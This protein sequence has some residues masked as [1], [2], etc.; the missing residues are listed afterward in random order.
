MVQILKLSLWSFLQF[1][2]FTLFKVQIFTAHRPET[3]YSLFILSER[4]VVIVN[5]FHDD[6][7]QHY[8]L[9]VKA[10]LNNEWRVLDSSV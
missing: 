10:S 8:C 9:V 1:P 6:T 4:A 7:L 2:V 5:G 3:H